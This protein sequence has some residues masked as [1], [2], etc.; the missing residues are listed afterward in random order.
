MTPDEFHG[1][2]LVATCLLLFC[3]GVWLAL[4]AA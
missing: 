2:I 4:K 3:A 1:A